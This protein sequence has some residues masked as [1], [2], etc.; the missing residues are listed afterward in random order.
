MMLTKAGLKLWASGMLATLTMSGFG[1]L[2]AEATE[3]WSLAEAAF[4]WLLVAPMVV[5]LL[6]RWFWLR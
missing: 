6:Q 4:L 3:Q 5:G 1:L 2:F